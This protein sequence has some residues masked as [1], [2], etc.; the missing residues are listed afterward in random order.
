MASKPRCRTQRRHAV[1]IE[2]LDRDPIPLPYRQRA[3]LEGRPLVGKA[4]VGL[5][6]LRWCDT[7]PHI[8][9]DRARHRPPRDHGIARVTIAPCGQALG[10]CRPRPHT[11]LMAEHADIADRQ[12]RGTYMNVFVADKTRAYRR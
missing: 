11:P 4:L 12:V 8:V 5:I 9:A 6:Q 2:A 3:Q 7:P 10:G 1:L